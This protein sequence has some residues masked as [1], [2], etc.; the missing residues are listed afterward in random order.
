MASQDV[1]EQSSTLIPDDPV[2]FLD[3]PR[4]H[5]TFT[6]PAGP[7]RPHPLQVTYSDYGYRDLES[8][9]REHVLLFCGPLMGSRFLHIAKDA[10]AKKHRVRII[11]PDRPGFG[12]ATPVPA[13]DRV[14]VWLEMV[15]ALLRHLGVRHVS[16]ASH[17]A[18]TIYALNTLLYLRHLIS[19]THPCVAL[20][21]PWIH[22]AHS[23][24]PL[25]KAL[26]RLPDAVLGQF[27][28]VAGFSQRNLAP[29]AGFSGGIIN[30]MMPGFRA[31][32]KLLPAQETS[33]APPVAEASE[34]ARMAGFEEEIWERL[35]KKVFAESVQGLSEEVVLL[36]KRADHPDYWGAWGDYDRFV[37]LLAEGEANL[38]AGVVSD[39]ARL[40]IR[41]YYAADDHLIGTGDGPKWFDDCWRAERRGDRIDFSS[42]VVP[43]ADHDTIVDFK[44]NVFERIF[45]QIA[46][47]DGGGGSS[48]PDVALGAE[49][50]E[51]LV[52]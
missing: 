42:C 29:V 9:E 7:N 48:S 38:D 6:L 41:V 3:D 45:R 52:V 15:P 37:T 27:H 28:A 33:P 26:S 49:G 46:G 8:P 43:G 19:P 40:D 35:I 4:F 31:L 17:S 2:A 50:E 32:A 13:A 22:P 21:T 20:I 23:G 18:G 24:V 44:F 16:V 36:L 14:R 51:P 10:L 5:Q 1:N 25:S 39:G 11:D 47:T 30:G 12:G 34:S